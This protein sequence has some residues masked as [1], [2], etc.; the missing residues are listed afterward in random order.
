M[1]M[2]NKG[3]SIERENASYLL[4][5]LEQKVGKAHI[6]AYMIPVMDY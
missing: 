6:M 1:N 2:R 4:N 5:N 3:V